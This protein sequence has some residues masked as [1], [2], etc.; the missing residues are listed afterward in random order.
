MRIRRT[1]IQY[2]LKRVSLTLFILKLA[3]ITVCI[4]LFTYM[5]AQYAG[6]PYVLITLV[7]LIA[8]YT[9]VMNKTVT[10]RH[11]YAV[12]GNTNR[13]EERRVGKEWRCRWWRYH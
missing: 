10:G 3:L 8:G 1:D 4:N 11:I 13:S 9:F 2:T 6:I 7:I 5:L 12:G